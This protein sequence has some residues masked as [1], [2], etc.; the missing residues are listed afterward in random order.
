MRSGRPASR[1]LGEAIRAARKE[2]GVSQ[3][4]LAHRCGLDRSYFGAIERGEF[5]ISVQ[6]LLRISAGLDISAAELLAHSLDDKP[7]PVVKRAAV[8]AKDGDA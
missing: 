6:T 4:V 8:G 5:N 3:E 7:S 2:Q 1:A